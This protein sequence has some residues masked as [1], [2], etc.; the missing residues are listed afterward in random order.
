[1][2]MR[3]KNRRNYTDLFTERGKKSFICLKNCLTHFG[4]SK[5]NIRTELSQSYPLSIF[6]DHFKNPSILYTVFCKYLNYFEW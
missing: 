3:Q 4:Y 5:F 1:M 2:E 6:Y